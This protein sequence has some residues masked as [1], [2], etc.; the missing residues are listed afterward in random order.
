MK[1]KVL[2]LFISILLII[3]LFPNKINAESHSGWLENGLSWYLV[4]GELEISGEGAMDDKEDP[5]EWGWVDYKNE[6]TKVVVMSGVTRIGSFAF[7]DLN[8]LEEA[9]IP[10]TV[11]DIGEE[12]FSYCE[13][14]KTIDILDGLTTIKTRAFEGC[15]ALSQILLP[16]S[17]TTIESY[18]FYKCS[19]LTSFII[20]SLNP[21]TL[22]S[23]AFNLTSNNL[24]IYAPESSLQLYR[25]ASNWSN[26]AIEEAPLVIYEVVNTVPGG[27]PT[28]FGEI[29][30]W[31]NGYNDIYVSV[32][33]SGNTFN[34]GVEHISYFG[35][36]TKVGNNY[37]YSCDG[38]D[39]TFVMTDGILTS[40]ICNG[41]GQ[42]C[43][44]TYLPR[45][46]VGSILPDDFPKDAASGWVSNQGFRSYIN[47]TKN[48]LIIMGYELS[49][50]DVVLKDGNN[51]TDYT[52]DEGARR[53]DLIFVME[54][55]ELK[56]IEYHK[57]NQLMFTFYPHSFL[58]DEKK[59]E[60][61]SNIDTEFLT[62][63][64][65]RSQINTETIKIN[66]QT[67]DNSKYTISG[68]NTKTTI[69]LKGD[70]IQTLAIGT[71]TL[72]FSL[73]KITSYDDDDFSE[74]SQNFEITK[75][76]VN[77]I[78][79]G[80]NATINKDNNKDYLIE[81]E[82]DYSKFYNGEEIIGNVK[83]D[84]TIVDPANYTHKEGS[85]VITLKNDYLKTLR[86]GAHTLR[87][88]TTDSYI[89]TSIIITD[90][91]NNTPHIVLNTG[92]N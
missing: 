83:I 13:K 77:D 35:V 73:T 54:S 84:N 41:F 66:G 17:V 19:N 5:S 23:D 3:A 44:G 22:S 57:N 24:K 50:Y 76:K 65:Y 74:I 90:G 28:L 70:Y 88:E 39:L 51:Y 63:S 67:I 33:Q 27:F 14:L 38:K 52:F 89:E 2:A 62:N 46:T 58:N 55:G 11:Q 78:I 21:P 49:L 9:T 7:S 87:I 12:A 79:I 68:D 92:I 37:H 20:K 18:A 80:K 45:T 61:G 16:K 43:N 25:D 59:I 8:N 72:S 31:T 53:I 1:N 69:T 4:S 10:S 32:H 30:A 40:V 86:N 34:V 71:Y 91:S 48:K 82:E 29:P 42:N 15:A 36:T 75:K 60:V 26:C 85:I 64:Y 81:F 6:I 47:T 56:C